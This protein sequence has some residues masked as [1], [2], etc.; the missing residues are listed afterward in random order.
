VTA[1]GNDVLGVTLSLDESVRVLGALELLLQ[2]V[3]DDDLRAFGRRT[4]LLV[5]HRMAR[6]IE[7]GSSDH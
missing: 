2:G 6:V 1:T 7:S 4:A 5:Q 3:M